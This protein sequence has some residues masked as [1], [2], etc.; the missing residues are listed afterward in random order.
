MKGLRSAWARAKLRA[1]PAGTVTFHLGA[2]SRGGLTESEG[3]E[4]RA[5]LS[6]LGFSKL[7]VLHGSAL[8]VGGE[9][10]VVV[11]PPGIGKST[12]CRELARRGE[13][14]FL[15]DGLVVVGETGDRWTLVETGTLEVLR[16]AAIVSAGPRRLVPRV[17]GGASRETG[18]R[19]GVI[20]KRVNR[21]LDLQAFRAGVLLAP[22][23]TGTVSR[24]LHPVDRIVVADEPGT[25]RHSWET[26]GR[27]LVALEDVAARAPSGVAVR[28]LS[29]AGRLEEVR[30]RLAAAL[31]G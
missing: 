29:A 6:E 2:W 20:R 18:S 21:A 25:S 26:D 31:R 16:R 14:T 13:G 8:L 28:R 27:A 7:V 3:E 23:R 11:G 12:A 22:R 30:A 10:V 4:A 24:R 15:E 1:F 19:G 9:T 17:S 5:L